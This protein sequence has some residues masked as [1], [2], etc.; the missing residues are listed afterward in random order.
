MTN[1]ETHLADLLLGGFVMLGAALLLV[2]LFRR[3]GIGAVLGYIVA[4]I[5]IG[6][7]GLGLIS[8]GESVLEFSEIGIILLLFLV[9]LELAPARLWRLRH[10]IFG[11]GAAQVVLCGLALF[12]IIYLT[13][14]FTV[15]AALVLGLPLAL[16]STAQVLPMLQSSGRLNTPSGEKA[17]SVLLFQDLSIIPLLT[18]VAALSRAPVSA[19]H[20]PTGWLAALY[21]ALAIIGLIIA[22]RYMLQPLLRII[23]TI[24]ERELFIVA[25]LVAVFGGAIL[26]EQ[27][28]LSPALGA[29]I[30]GVML[31]D[32]PYRHELEAD[33]DPF[34]SL[35]LGFFFVAVG[36]ML[37]INVVIANLGFVIA[38]ALVLV[39]VKI[40]IIAVLARGF[41]LDW[42]PAIGMGMLLSQGGEFGFVLFAEAR[43]ALLID[44]Q[45]VSLFNAVVTL[46]MVTTPFLML[47][48]N[49]YANRWGT[50]SDVELTD[51]A[52]APSA[53]VIVVGHG[54][55]GQTA[56]QMLMAANFSV[57]LID[58]NPE[59]IDVSQKFGRKVFYGDGTRIDVLR[60]AGAAE[61]CAI[62]FCIDGKTLDAQLLAMVRETFPQL[63]VY[64]RLYDRRHRF[65]LRDGDL[66]GHVREVY[67]SA[68]ELARQAMRGIDLDQTIIEETEREYR[69][70]DRQRLRMQMDEASLLA[71]RH[72]GFGLPGDNAGNVPDQAASESR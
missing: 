56:S 20:G 54:R 22:G 36:M 14:N 60:R 57:T 47:L 27:L 61:A 35:L 12:A 23:G 3:F 33:I 32:S 21:G 40:A 44:P 46:S 70:I 18:I 48:A 6:P 62:L 24:A 49:R 72:L 45:A 16:S 10:A 4:G 53:N 7:S 31:A 1:E 64:A 52:D 69:R 59:Q 51:P 66:D 42:L 34:R 2:L 13:Q 29:F 26:M 37:D 5:I 50:S 55:F 41:G 25:G 67:E 68:I 30:A 39:L 8:E 38:A 11:L 28:G 19:E 43:A 58:I 71:G 17:F 15:Q 9:G 65:D 63:K